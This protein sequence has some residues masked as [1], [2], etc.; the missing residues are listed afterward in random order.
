MIGGYSV[1]GYYVGWVGFLGCWRWRWWLI[2]RGDCGGW[3]LGEG[4]GRLVLYFRVIVEGVGV[5]MGVCYCG[6]IVFE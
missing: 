4:R 5:D 2:G 6:C 1:G 3:D